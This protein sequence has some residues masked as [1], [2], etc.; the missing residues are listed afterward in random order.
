[1]RFLFPWALFFLVFPLGL[2]LWVRHGRAWSRALTLALLVVAAA[3]PE[4][5]LREKRERVVLVVDRSASVAEAGEETFWELAR[6]VTQRG[7]ELGAVVF[8]GL[9]A[10]AQLPRAALPPT[11]RVPADLDPTHTDLGAALDLALALLEDSGQIVIISDGRA[12]GGDT[13]AAVLR[14]RANRIPIHA[15]PVGRTD[16][17]R[18]V[19]LSGPT[20]IPPG[21][22]ELRA[23]V[24]AERETLVRLVL[25]VNGQEKES[26]TREYP[27]GLHEERFFLQASEPGTHWLTVQLMDENDP[28]PENNSLSWVVTVG[29]PPA[30]L[31]VGQGGSATAQ[32]LAQAGLPY[33]VRE[34]LMPTDLAHASLV[35][36]DDYPLGQLGPGTVEALR[37]WVSQGGS[38]VVVQGRQALTGYVG[39]LEEV[40]P[41]TYAVPQRYQEATAAIVFV[42]DRSASMSG[43]AGEVLKIDL[44]KDAAAAAAELI[45]EEDWVGVL[46]FDRSP[47]WLTLPG[48]ARETKPAV[49]TA[50]AGLTPSGGTDLW[51]AVEEAL[52]A[53]A[54]VPARI[55][56]ILL[57]SD[58]KTLREGRDFQLL[59]AQ[60]RESGVGLT[61]LAIGP[62]ADLE[63]LSGLAAAGGGEMYVLPDPRQLPA[64]LVQETKRA[65]RPRFLEGQF[66]ALP[67]PAGAEFAELALPPLLGY[68]L[69]FPKPTAEVALLS[70]LGDPLLAFG[71]LGSGKI[72]V[73]NADLAGIWTKE[74]F[75]SPSLGPFFALVL[76]R[77]WSEREPVEIH[78]SLEG[79]SL[80]VFLDVDQGGRWVHG[81]RFKGTLGSGVAETVLMFAQTGPG[82][83]EAVVPWPAPGAYVVAVSDE[84]GQYWGS[85]VIPVPYPSEYAAFGPDGEALRTVTQLTGGRILEDE[86]IPVLAGEKRIW[87]SLWP[88]A[89]WASAAGFLADLTLRKLIPPRS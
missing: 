86:E 24:L 84:G 29:D 34:I 15:F 68:A 71:R 63:V 85:A 49:F 27:P 56:H 58:G 4:L 5:A 52:A 14:A 72:A 48:P 67:G 77:T 51:P 7:G 73:F 87:V 61:S 32:L 2:A 13:A 20:R 17:L 11:L 40:L 57:I 46:A 16:P 9:P 47:F 25:W 80:R 69:T 35:I 22:F 70:S 89:L 31:V 43:R 21:N 50:L 37:A 6:N 41:V 26:R 8:A 19:S 38:L 10:V 83:Y 53:L 66:A 79:E 78:W 12:T 64:V 44:L 76:S 88:W 36:L 65:L 30:I 60:V 45:P 18:L 3:Q 81:L 75:V 28:I 82:R 23:Q 62:D 1:M 42:L 39:P 59:Y 33:R 54:S 55:R 74:W